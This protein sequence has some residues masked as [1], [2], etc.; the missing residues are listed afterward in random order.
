[1]RMRIST[2]L[3]LFLLFASLVPLLLFGLVSL[4]Q[5]KKTT[6]ISVIQ[7]NANVSR[8]AAEQ[9][10]QYVKNALSL[11]EATAQNINHADLKDWQKERILKNY[12]NR[13]NEFNEITVWNLEGQ[14]SATSRLGDIKMDSRVREAFEKAR[15]GHSY[16]SSVYIK[17]DLSPAI[18]AAYPIYRLTEASGVLVAELNLLQMWHLV[19][20][21]RIGKSGILH[22]IESTGLLIATG[23]G[24]RKTDVFQQKPFEPAEKISTILNP[25]GAVFKNPFG[26]EVLAAGT[27]LPEPIGWTVLVE[28]PTAEAYALARKIGYLL[29]GIMGTILLLALG[30]GYYA[31]K[32]QVVDPISTL[33]QATEELARGNLD[34][35]ISLKTGDEFEWLG[36]AFNQM[37]ARLKELQETLVREER[38]AMFGKIASGLAHDLKHPIQA[39]ETS[40]RLM[41][42]LYDDP[43]FRATFRKTVE[44]EFA[45]VN[46]FLENLHNLTHEVPHHPAPI[47]ISDL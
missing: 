35:R 26:E 34:Y 8:R 14:V 29:L 43:E 41:E 45:K 22:V 31:G 10:E 38:H 27:R 16:L 32:K 4:W 13:F 7:G 47:K 46:L 25:Q 17:E 15:E 19:D 28:E 24:R 21:I 2:K 11:L 20:S 9:I 23:D 39:I 3:S 40:S 33:S 1:M 42:K 5:L 44:R 6:A 37:A 18:T 12:T 36:Q 30:F